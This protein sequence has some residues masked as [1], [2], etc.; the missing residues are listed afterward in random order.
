MVFSEFAEEK[1]PVGA[2]H[3]TDCCPCANP[4][5]EI[6]APGQAVIGVVP[7]STEKTGTGATHPLFTYEADPEGAKFTVEPLLSGAAFGSGKAGP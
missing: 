3:D 6:V 2:D 4:V 7:A 5:N 1:L